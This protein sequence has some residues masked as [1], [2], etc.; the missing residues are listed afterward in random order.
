VEGAFKK[1]ELDNNVP[2]ILQLST[3]SV[4][5]NNQLDSSRSKWEHMELGTAQQ[6][7]NARQEYQISEAYRDAE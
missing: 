1:R 5:L 6:N 4:S 7:L 3:V 2:I